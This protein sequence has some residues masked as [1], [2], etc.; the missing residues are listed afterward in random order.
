MPDLD[1]FAAAEPAEAKTCGTCG[2]CRPSLSRPGHYCAMS[3]R[4]V[5]EC[6][7]ADE[8]PYYEVRL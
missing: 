6:Q 2:E 5:L 7:P 8:C 1:L 4:D 3:L